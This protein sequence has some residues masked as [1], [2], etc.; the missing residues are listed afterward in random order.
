MAKLIFFDT[1]TTGNTEKDFLCQIAYKSGNQT[2]AG[3]YKPPIKIPPEASA[4]HHITNKMVRD[5]PAFKESGDLPRVKK[6]FE[7]KDAIVVAHNAPFDLLM[8]KKEGIE[9]EKFIC[10]LRVARYL[11]KEEKIERFNLQYLR[12]LLDLDVE[13]DAHDALGDVLVLEKLFERLK[14]KMMVPTEVGIPTGVGKE[15]NEEEVLEKMVEVSS[16][17]SLLHTFKFGK[18]N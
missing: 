8:I 6:V 2:F 10:T 14:N 7:D 5:L 11:D 3:L 16:H 12:Y 13:A 15:L 17:P 18:H 1:E 9:P 4:V